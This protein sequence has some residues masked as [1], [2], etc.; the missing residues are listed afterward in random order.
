MTVTASSSFTLFDPAN[1]DIGTGNIL[2][3]IIS[4]NCSYMNGYTS[5]SISLSSSSPK[6]IVS[7]SS[8]DLS[9]FV[10]N[11]ACTYF[12][13]WCTY[14][15]HGDTMYGNSFYTDLVINT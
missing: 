14:D 15:N 9:A 12:R 11:G 10:A 7:T 2:S 6:G 1:Y 8:T 4:C 3:D 13:Y 5:L